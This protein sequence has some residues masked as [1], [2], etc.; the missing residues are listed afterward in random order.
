MKKELSKKYEPQELKGR[1]DYDYMF[2][3][4][5]EQIIYTPH[6]SGVQQVLERCKSPVK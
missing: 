3:F 5:N 4:D 1:T 6:K 2:D